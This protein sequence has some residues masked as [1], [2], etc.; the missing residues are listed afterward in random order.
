MYTVYKT[1]NLET[2]MFYIGVHK[3]SNPND[4]Y[5]GSGLV[6][7]AAI[8]KYGRKSFVKEV[9]FE[10]EN[11]AEAYAKERELVNQNLLTSGVAYNLAIGGV[12]S[13]D[14]PNGE[15]KRTALRGNAH[16]QW[17]K[18]Q[19][20]ES[21]AQRSATLK[22]TYVKNPR[23]AGSWEKSA[24]KK[25]GVPSPVKGRIQTAEANQK[26]AITHLNLPKLVC[27]VCGRHISPSNFLRH[28]ATHSE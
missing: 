13:I 20:A 24:A 3:T 11:S 22:Q 26:R 18:S 8:K 28:V 23:D 9:L 17:G 25:R 2:G 27:E 4:G 5:L 6:L 16:P 1:T 14:W 10:F 7:K 15:R 12:P 19:T 21:N